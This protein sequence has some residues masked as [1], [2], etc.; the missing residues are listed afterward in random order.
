MNR[1][2]TAISISTDY[3]T[4][5]IIQQSLR[6]SKCNLCGS[7]EPAIITNIKVALEGE[8]CP[9]CKSSFRHQ[10]G[11][12][13]DDQLEKLKEIDKRLYELDHSR[14]ELQFE[15]D[16]IEK[17]ILQITKEY[18]AMRLEMAQL[19]NSPALRVTKADDNHKV[20][21][22]LLEGQLNIIKDKDHQK[23]EAHRQREKLKEDAFKLRKRLTQSYQEAEEGFLPIF[24]ALASKFTGLPVNIQ[25]AE[26]TRNH[27]P[28]LRFSLEMGDTNR[29]FQHQLSESQ[30]F[31]IDIALRMAFVSYVAGGSKAGALFID[32]PEGSLDIA[33]E[34]NA[35][36]MFAKFAEDGNQLILTSNI[37][38]SG[39]IRRLAEVCGSQRFQLQRMIEWANLSDVQ[40]SR[41]NLFEQTLDAIERL[42]GR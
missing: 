13:N 42:L 11:N 1:A 7:D 17:D 8:E 10:N 27:R 22:S 3:G 19:E 34:T 2:V 29:Q 38:S 33:Y 36:E 30:R 25:M 15:R 31:F 5:S 23:T 18:E 21:N 39:L 12:I 41:L 9:I 37:N 28:E 32:T 4:S 26:Q 24:Q 16:I 40:L 6:E 14:K 35:G 20:I